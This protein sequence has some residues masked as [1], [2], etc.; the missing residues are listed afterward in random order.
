MP[1]RS[2]I[3]VDYLYG[4][5]EL[6]EQSGASPVE[7]CES[8]NIQ[9]PE[10]G[11]VSLDLLAS[12]VDYAQTSLQGASLGYQLGNRMA[13]G[14][15]GYLGYAA[16]SSHTVYDALL[17]DEQYISTRITSL[18]FIASPY[19]EGME[20]TLSFSEPMG[21]L[22]Q[23]IVEFVIF[24]LSQFYRALL[25]SSQLTMTAKVRYPQPAHS[26]SHR[27]HIHW[28]FD[29]ANNSL[30]I[31]NSVLQQKLPSADK[32]LLQLST[33]QCR[34]QLQSYKTK[35]DNISRR[36]RSQL[37]SR[38]ASP[39][40]LSELAKFQGVSER[41]YRRL[42]EKEGT[43]YNE[44]LRELRIER[45]QHLLRTTPLAVDDIAHIIGYDSPN[46]FKRLFKSWTH[47]TP[48]QYRKSGRSE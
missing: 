3:H 34:A 26:Y 36:T 11:M 30:W 46:S 23:F 28:Q 12:L 13:P 45:A 47:Q 14:M 42:L 18:G 38:L 17:I 5:L 39:P 9:L 2:E 10:E 33:E 20:L 27:G 6:L 16:Q 15:H 22:E 21:N 25:P 31:P 1:Y 19:Q 43:S 44:L 48:G 7:L 40:T 29:C 4:L 35:F 37:A 32:I 8:L 41:T 24:S